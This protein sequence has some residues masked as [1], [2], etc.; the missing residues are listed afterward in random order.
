MAWLPA[1]G[2]QV[3]WGSFVPNTSHPT[4][5][6]SCF[7]RG[8]GRSARQQALQHNHISTPAQV[9]SINISFAKTSKMARPKV[10]GREVRV[11]PGDRLKGRE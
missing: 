8:N 4:G 1:T 2:L 11:P 9:T 3:T 10:K 7:S 6:V 5:L